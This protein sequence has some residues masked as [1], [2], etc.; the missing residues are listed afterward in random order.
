[1]R[2]YFF[3]FSVI[4]FSFLA[5]CEKSEQDLRN[6]TNGIFIV[7]EGVFGSNNGSISLY[8]PDKMLVTNNIFEDSN[9]RPVGDVV[10]SFGIAGAYGFIVVNNSQKVEV[11]NLRD[12]STKGVIGGLSYPRFFVANETHGFISNGNMEGTV[13]VIDLI[14]FEKIAEIPVGYGPEQMVIVDDFLYVANS[15]GW[16]YDKTV[17][18]ID[19]NTWQVI[20][21]IEVGDIP[22]AMQKDNQDNLWVLSRGKV[23]YDFETW[24]IIEETDSRLVK[25]NTTS[26]EVI[27]NIV[28]GVTGDFSYPTSLSLSG[29]GSTLFFNE[30]DGIYSV[31]TSA[32]SVSAE[33]VMPGSFQGFAVNPLTNEFF[34]LKVPNYTSAGS[35]GIYSGTGVLSGEFTVGIGPNMVVFGY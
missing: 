1:M 11:V 10:Q 22:F 18:V 4:A 26:N 34:C 16:G 24:E 33:Q 5:S 31:N 7:N 20:K 25:I 14:G 30:S 3:L 21:T 8:N 6:Y 15:G 13:I 32:S 27:S 17:S 29:D 23:V 9:G 12:F 28:I 2:N 19:L 35:L